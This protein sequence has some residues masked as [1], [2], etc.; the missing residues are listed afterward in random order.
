MRVINNILE[1]M[2]TYDS[3]KRISL[4]ELY[5]HRIFN[6][7][8]GSIQEEPI[9]SKKYD[10]LFCD[11][12]LTPI[13]LNVGR[14]LYREEILIQSYTLLTMYMEKQ[15]QRPSK[16]DFFITC[17]ACMD[18]MSYTFSMVPSSRDLF[19]KVVLGMRKIDEHQ[20]FDRVI[21]IV[22]SVQFNLF[23]NGILDVIEHQDKN[24]FYSLLLEIIELEAEHSKKSINVHH[25][26]DSYF[27]SNVLDDEDDSGDGKMDVSDPPD[28]I[29][30]PTVKNTQTPASTPIFAPLK[31]GQII[32][33]KVIEIE[34]PEQARVK[35][36]Y[37]KEDKE[38]TEHDIDQTF[39]QQFKEHIRSVYHQELLKKREEEER[40]D[41]LYIEL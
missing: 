4:D 13:F 17:M 30:S 40:G 6:N 41:V 25:L 10:T 12:D 32:L 36:A 29:I 24:V 39:L 34:A 15:R 11:K 5:H 14:K 18:I 8:R 20:I 37:K 9:V 38:I 26:L 21:E 19:R 27:S 33:D 2:L 35:R 22:K 31:A 16:R 23:Y 3:M 7:I 28:V 1:R